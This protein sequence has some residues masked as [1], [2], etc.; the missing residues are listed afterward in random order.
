MI[1]SNAK[2]AMQFME[3]QME[4]Q[5]TIDLAQQ[6]FIQHFRMRFEELP[7]HVQSLIIAKDITEQEQEEF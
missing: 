4:K 7:H 5:R 6:I 3:E 2:E 1:F